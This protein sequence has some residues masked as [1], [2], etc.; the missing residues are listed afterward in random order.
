MSVEVRAYHPSDLASLYRICL[1]TGDN[2]GDATDLYSDPLLPGHLWAAP[3]AMLE[4]D[5]CFV[6]TAR[7]R[8]IGYI[9]G[10]ADTATFGAR[11]ETDWFPPLRRQ[12]PMST[13]QKPSREALTIR[14]IHQ[15]H[16]R[17]NRWPQFPAHLHID[18]LPEGQKQGWGR[19]LMDRFCDRLTQLGVPGVFLGVSAEN[20]NAVDFYRHIGFEALPGESQVFGR[21]L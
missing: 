12:Y 18:I 10:T 3:Y 13:N 16:D 1:Q 17:V 5:L 9:L 6:L 14:Q 15:G 11:C 4:P 19:R 7:H 21:R 20:R 8:P 2:G